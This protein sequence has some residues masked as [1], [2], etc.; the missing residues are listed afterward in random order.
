MRLSLVGCGYVGQTIAQHL[1]GRADLELTVT[2]TGE[3]RRVELSAIAD[4]V[5][6]ISADD[7]DGLLTALEGRDAAIFCLGPKGNR[8]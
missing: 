6:V 4:Q 2:T 8:K 1:Q 3:E 7:P 5:L